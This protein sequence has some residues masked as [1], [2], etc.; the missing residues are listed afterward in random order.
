VGS[1]ATRTYG[2]AAPLLERTRPNLEVLA[3]GLP[4]H[5]DKHRPQRPVLLAVDQQLGEGAALLEAPRMQEPFAG[6]TPPSTR[7]SVDAA[8]LGRW[9]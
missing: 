8:L 9:S 4:Q 2:A 5:A 1:G 7:R 3:I 6:L